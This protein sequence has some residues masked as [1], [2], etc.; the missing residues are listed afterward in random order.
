[1]TMI[2]FGN[3]DI[4][5]VKVRC[6]F[7]SMTTHRWVVNCAYASCNNGFRL[8]RGKLSHQNLSKSNIWTGWSSCYV[9]PNFV[10]GSLKNLKR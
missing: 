5:Q 10:G 7:L 2:A 6:N 9:K 8:C 4:L 3:S 1:M